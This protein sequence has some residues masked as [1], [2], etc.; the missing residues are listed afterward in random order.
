MIS[1]AIGD[2][3]RMSSCSWKLRAVIKDH[4]FNVEVM[5]IASDDHSKGEKGQE[6]IRYNVNGVLLDNE[7]FAKL[8]NEIVLTRI[9]GQIA[10]KTEVFYYGEYP[11]KTERKRTLVIR[12][13]QVGLWKN[14]SIQPHDIDEKFYEVVTNPQISA[15]IQKKMHGTQAV[16]DDTP[17][18]EE[19]GV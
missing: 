14:D 2:A 17:K 11:D 7:G 6:Q 5:E 3:D 9:T 16:K 8:K 4:P 18:T 19:A 15:V 1:S 10:G 13:G 12:E